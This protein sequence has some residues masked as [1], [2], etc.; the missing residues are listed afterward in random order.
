MHY[1]FEEIVGC[2]DAKQTIVL[3]WSENSFSG[4]ALF[5]KWLFFI[6]AKKEQF[7]LSFKFI[8]IPIKI[9]PIDNSSFDYRV[10]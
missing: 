6:I 2:T 3:K 4:L 8:L 5:H 1:S 7:L 9:L 10:I